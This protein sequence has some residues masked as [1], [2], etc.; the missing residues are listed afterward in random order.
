VS[1]WTSVEDELPKIGYSFLA[2]Y[3]NQHPLIMIAWLNVH[4]NYVL[5][6]SGGDITGHGSYPKFSHWAS[7]PE[8]PNKK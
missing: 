1:K 3:E 8:P 5:Q 4:G 6:G 7:L 2:Y